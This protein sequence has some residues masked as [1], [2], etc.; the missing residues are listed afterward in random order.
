MGV[1]W[2]THEGDM[3]LNGFMIKGC[4][5]NPSEMDT[6]L[7]SEGTSSLCEYWEFHTTWEGKEVVMPGGSSHWANRRG[8]VYYMPT[9]LIQV[10]EGWEAE[11]D[12]E[13]EQA[14]MLVQWEEER[15]VMAMTRSQSKKDGGSAIKSGEDTGLVG[16]EVDEESVAQ[17]LHDKY[18]KPKKPGCK[19][20]EESYARAKSVVARTTSTK[21]PEED[22]ESTNSDLIILNEPHCNGNIAVYHTVGIKSEVGY[23]AAVTN[24]LSATQSKHA[25]IAKSWMQHVARMHGRMQFTVGA[26]KTGPGSEFMGKHKEGN[27]D[28]DVWQTKGD[29]GRHECNAR[30]EAE[31][32]AVEEQ[33]SA[34]TLAGRVNDE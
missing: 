33:A 21:E 2:V 14:E 6:T 23:A 7:L 19:T 1:M 15:R 13:I 12:M 29:S 22:Y 17:A 24:R 10:R 16:S 3:M 18:H 11:L 28:D 25:K 27:L 9:Q 31:N 34:M 30:I 5:I 26:T 8:T 4:L 32:R 20:C